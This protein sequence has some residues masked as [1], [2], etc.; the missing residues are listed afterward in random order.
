VRA[1]L[2]LLVPALRE[3]LPSRERRTIRRDERAA[4]LVPIVEDGGPLRVILTRRTAHLPTHQ[5]DVAFPGGRVDP[6]DADP[7]R[8]ALREAEEEIGLASGRVE[9]LGPLDDQVT[10]EDR[11]AVTPVVGW[12]GRLPPLKAKPDEVARIFTIPIADLA[13][14]GRWVSRFEMS[15]RRGRLLLHFFDH[16]GEILWGLSARIVVSML[17]LTPLGSPVAGG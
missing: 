9:V 13:D 17:A 16:D 15:P 1:P 8:T 12:I 6:G 11:F 14:P 2:S 7:C 5:G 10:W 3:A 4:V